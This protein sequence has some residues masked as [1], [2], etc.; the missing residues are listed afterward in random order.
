MGKFL[1]KRNFPQPLLALDEELKGL[2]YAFF[3]C[4]NCVK[5]EIPNIMLKLLLSSGEPLA[6]HSCG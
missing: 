2:L 6:L 5:E 1:L 3:F 4:V